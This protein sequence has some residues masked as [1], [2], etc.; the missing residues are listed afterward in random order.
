[1]TLR[2]GRLVL[3]ALMG[4]ALLQVG[5]PPA[6][7]AGGWSCPIKKDVG[8]LQ[9]VHGSHDGVDMAAGPFPYVRGRKVRAVAGGTVTYQHDPGG[10]GKWINF[11]AD[12]GRR[13]V[14]GHLK[15]E[16]LVPNGAHVLKDD[17]I[18]RIGMSGNATAP[19]LHFEVHRKGSDAV[20]DPVPKL[21][22]CNWINPP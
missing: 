6:S 18:G 21:D 7:A 13:L 1:M 5:A 20:M 16:Q 9:G 22:H 19:H 14:Y 12:G 2:V 11:H 10:Y 15:K 3:V 4:A 8:F 17:A